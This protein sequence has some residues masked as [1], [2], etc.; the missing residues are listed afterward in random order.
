MKKSCSWFT[1]ITFCAA[2]ALVAALGMAALF[3]GVSVALAGA[4]ALA[5]SDAGPQNPPTQPIVTGLQTYTGMITD[6]HCGA[7]HKM[8]SDKNPAQC[9]RMC[10]RNGSR[11]ILIDGEK[12]YRV[13]GDANEL[14]RLAGQRAKVVGTLVGTTIKM[15]ST[16]SEQ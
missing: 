13:D 3:A 6:D 8:D 5:L 12:R 9:A 1:L 10:V 7:R 4:D 2:A 14:G 16:A 11:Y 15:S